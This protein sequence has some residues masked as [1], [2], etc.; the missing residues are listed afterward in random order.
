MSDSPI[1]QTDDN[2]QKAD[3]QGAANVRVNFIGMD[4][5]FFT[6]L[7]VCLSVAAI[8]WTTIAQYINSRETRMAQYYA[9]QLEVDL[10]HAGINPTPDPW[11]KKDKP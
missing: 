8:L 1:T 3:G 7:A 10:A 6:A 4:K 11:R 2:S 9:I 5:P